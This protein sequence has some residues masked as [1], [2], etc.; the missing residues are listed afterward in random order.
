MFVCSYAHMH[1][2]MQE[3]LKARTVEFSSEVLNSESLEE[4][5]ENCTHNFCKSSTHSKASLLKQ[6]EPS[7]PLF[8]KIPMF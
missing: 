2:W 1:T 6:Q 7:F 5:A 3:G 8:L 4:H